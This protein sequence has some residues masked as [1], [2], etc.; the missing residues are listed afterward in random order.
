M[1]TITETHMSRELLDKLPEWCKDF[2][3]KQYYLVLTDDADSLLSCQRLKTK[4]GLEIG[5]FYDF[6]QGLFVND[7]ITDEGWKTP[8]FVDLSVSEGY[9]FDNHYSFIN[10][11]D[12]VNPNVYKR[13]YYNQKYCG[14]TLMLLCS[15][16][17]GVDRMNETLRTVLCAV[18][19]FYIGYYNKGGKYKD[20]NLWWLDK[21]GLTEYLLP[22]L[23]EHDN[24]YFID[25]ISDYQLREK[26]WIDDEGYLH[27]P[28]FGVPGVQFNKEFS[29]EQVFTDKLQAMR[30]HRQGKPIFVSASTFENSYVLNLKQQV[31]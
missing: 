10:N 31:S 9:A 11:P 22:I 30:M 8:I 5:G 23:E 1:N 28:A 13:P 24:Q 6:K 18:D 20:V 21:L 4:F 29:I 7:E 2:D 14:S 15:L 26:I 17:G 19:G 27:C 12:K 16:Y 25:F 3:P